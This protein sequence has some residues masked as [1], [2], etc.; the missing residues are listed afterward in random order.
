MH[1]E[2][3]GNFHRTFYRAVEATSVTPWA[4]R[5]LDRALAATVVSAIRHV[6]PE[7]TPEQAVAT[8]KDHPG[9]RARVRD[10]II[11]R[12]PSDAIAGGATALAAQIDSLIDAWLD[13][14]DVQTTGGGAFCY[15]AAK[16]PR[17]LLHQPLEAGVENLPA[18]QRHFLCGRS[19]RDV[20]AGVLLKVRD[21]NG[22][23]IANAD[24]LQ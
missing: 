19:M 6:D 9:V 23:P 7:M 17:R 3:F 13:T 4:A 10:A 21:P 8:L 2:Q 18:A 14:A 12:A 24:D 16:S 22:S 5:A 20:E 11:S 15:S 1:F